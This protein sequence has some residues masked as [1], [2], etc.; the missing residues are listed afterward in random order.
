M[1][2]EMSRQFMWLVGM[3]VTTLVAIVV[4]LISASQAYGL[5]RTYFR[6]CLGLG[7]PP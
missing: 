7:S 4:A 6:S 3:H 2:G 5:T 1:T